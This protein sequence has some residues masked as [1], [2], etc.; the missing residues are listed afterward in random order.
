MPTIALS[1]IH[2]LTRLVVTWIVGSLDEDRVQRSGAAPSPWIV[3]P[4]ISAS[5]MP[6]RRAEVMVIEVISPLRLG[7][8]RRARPSR[9]LLR[10]HWHSRAAGSLARAKTAL[11][12]RPDRRTPGKLRRGGNVSLHRRFFAIV[13]CLCA[14]SAVHAGSGVLTAGNGI[15]Q[16]HVGDETTPRKG[17]AAAGPRRPERYTRVAPAWT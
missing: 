8:L 2:S 14:A 12:E 5:T 15:Y 10:C 3:A 7:R 11:T 1:R 17:P 6:R 9:G 16:V 13:L 4:A